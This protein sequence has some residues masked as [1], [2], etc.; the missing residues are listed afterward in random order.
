MW[1][2]LGDVPIC[3]CVIKCGMLHNDCSPAFMNCICCG[4][5]TERGWP[6]GSGNRNRCGS[7]FKQNPAPCWR[8]WRQTC[9]PASSSLPHHDTN[10]H[11][12]KF[13]LSDLSTCTS[14]T[15]GCARGVLVLFIS[16]W[17]CHLFQ[18]QSS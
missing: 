18:I 1:T 4:V 10:I 13:C 5:S 15:I 3:K 6:C 17:P 2:K 11:R 8:H 12:N 7:K 14:P 9:C 16:H